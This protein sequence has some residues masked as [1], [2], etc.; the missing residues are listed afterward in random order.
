MWVIKHL[1]V[2]LFLLAVAG[3]HVFSQDA[4]AEPLDSL[5]MDLEKRFGIVF[6]Y[7]DASIEGI[8]V[9]VPERYTDIDT[10]LIELERQ[11]RLSFIKI[12]SRYIAI[13]MREAGRTISGTIVDQST[14]ER[15]VDA[16]VQSGSSFEVS[17]ETGSF[18]IRIDDGDD[19]LL[20]ISHLGYQT[21]YVKK[22]DW[23]PD[24]S[25]YA[26]KI[27]IQPLE[28]V[29]VD[30]IARGISKLK[31]GSVQVNTRNLE[32]LPG[33]VN[34]DILHTVQILPGIHSMNETVSEINTRGGTN[35]QNLVLWDGVKMYQ[36][37]H[38]FGLISAFNSNLIHRATIIK[39][40]ASVSYDEGV[41]GVIDMRQQDYPVREVEIGAG[42]DMLSADL[43]AKIPLGE[44][45]SLVMGAR[46]SINQLVKTPT[47]KSYFKRAFEHTEIMLQPPGTDTILETN[48][49]FSFYDVSARLIYDISERDKL[50]LSILR[51]RN[52]ILFDERATIG[53]TV[54]LR[55]SYLKQ[56]NQLAGLTYLRSHGK[57]QETALSGF[58]SHYYLDGSNSST[59]NSLFHLQENEVLD[60]GLKAETRRR[61]SRTVE[62]SG[63]YQFREVGI[64]NQDN[65]RNP[66]Y[67]REVKDVLRIHSLYAET[68]LNEVGGKMYMRAGL[69]SNYYAKFN[70]FSLEPRV[71]LSYRLGRRFSLEAHAERKSQFTTQLIDFQTDFLGI[72]KRRWVL[73]NNESVPLVMSL[74]F[75]AGVQYNGAHFLASV[76]G[77]LKR[78]G[79]IISP[80][81][82]FQ[83]QFQYIFATGEYG[84]QGVELLLNRRFGRSGTWMNYT[85]AK[86]SYYFEAFTPSDFPNNLDVR[87][88]L[89]VGG[90]YSLKELEFSAGFNYRT[91][92][93]YTQPAVERLNER[94]EIMYGEPNSSR[95]SDYARLDVSAKY[96]FEIKGVKSEIGISLWNL[97]NRRNVYN[98]FYRVNRENEI[99]EVTQHTLG[100][101]PNVS[102][103]VW[104]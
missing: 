38:F 46:H 39:N 35:D 28:E 10:Y 59:Y 90:S 84:A 7:T 2:I 93:P 65:I 85:L 88:S 61:V 82:G 70:S 67:S 31:D 23:D 6:N 15:L 71:A 36:T 50:R 34:P 33:L 86:N 20:V 24:R 3:S 58:V 98:I 92:R 87:H 68:E 55:E 52:S 102:W 62:L 26:M 80:S 27:D 45:L 79:G 32:V 5:L 49:D 74:Q 41:S 97:L 18:S 81:Q 101:T 69:R 53:D 4:D 22:D 19:T 96:L 12:D 56:S 40:G 104:F 57:K 30:Y 14:G 63:G 66:G 51:N 89:S 16:V 83:N 37:G 91:G 9:S 21:L 25:V 99:E 94:N 11:T 78:A 75:S 103:R 54:Y 60:W 43:T 95:L 42:V 1:T 47:Y 29:R 77:Y 100:F 44:K 17:D 76:E 8:R 64:R 13:R 73:A 72:E 48:Q